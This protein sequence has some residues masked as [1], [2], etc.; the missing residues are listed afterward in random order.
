M[1]EQMNKILGVEEL[2]GGESFE[3][4]YLP[5]HDSPAFGLV[6]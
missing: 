5:I 6:S 3:S 2:G 1:V 4:L